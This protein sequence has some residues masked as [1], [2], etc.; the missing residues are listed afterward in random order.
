MLSLTALEPCEKTKKPYPNWSKTHKKKQKNQT[1]Q[2]KTHAASIL[3]DPQLASE[4]QPWV[5]VAGQTKAS[6]GSALLSPLIF[7]SLISTFL[8]SLSWKSGA[9]GCRFFLCI[10]FLLYVRHSFIGRCKTLLLEHDR[11]GGFLKVLWFDT[12]QTS[13]LKWEIILS[14][15]QLKY[16]LV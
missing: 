6:R 9:L 2:S 14:W 3:A 1:H 15:R 5:F 12:N 11:I 4:T 8:S 16:Y 10:F 13:K 7:L